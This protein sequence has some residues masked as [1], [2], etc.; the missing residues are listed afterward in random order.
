MSKITPVRQQLTSLVN[1]KI[2]SSILGD[3]QGFKKASVEYAK[4]AVDNF[5]EVVKMDKPSAKISLFSKPGFNI[6]KV[7]FLNLFRKKTPEEKAFKKMFEEY[8]AKSNFD[9]F[10]KSK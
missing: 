7:W 2:Y 10:I 6:L 4:L 3:Y 5:D 8:K 1:E 9:T